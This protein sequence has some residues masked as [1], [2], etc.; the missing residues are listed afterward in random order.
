LRLASY[1]LSV[2]RGERRGAAAAVVRA[3]L[4]AA[5]AFYALALAVRAAA[6]ALGLCRRV[7]VERAVIS[8]GNIVAGGTG[9][10]PMV[11]HLARRLAAHGS[12]PA[13]VARG[14]KA[15][16]AGAAND[17]AMVL[18]ENLPD[19]PQVLDPDRV[20]GAR[21][22]I[23][24]HGAG[25][26]ILDDGFQHWRIERD[27]DLVLVDALEPFGHGHL[28]PRGLLRERP[29]ALG[30]ADAVAITRADLCS[31]DRLAALR[32]EIGRLAPGKPL[33]E[34]VDEAIEPAVLAGKRI[35]AFCGIGNP[36]GFFRR[37]E[38]LGATLVLR[39]AFQDHHAYTP[40]DLAEVREAARRAG[41][42]AIVTTQKDA[43]KLRGFAG[44]EAVL[45]LRIRAAIRS[46]EAELE[47]LVAE[48]AAA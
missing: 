29:G 44:E 21:T 27:L 34:V 13:I 3:V 40:A 43:V 6:Y 1:Y 4:A 2:V 20:R 10:T 30:R 23:E 19:V 11:E 41:A 9:K 28:L 36:E 22:A 32:A 42:E 7:R 14:Y 45:V 17:E 38:R 47:R 24:R 12:R 39:L 25:C 26:V 48:A 33:V 15:A 31:P 35:A 18:R 8:V 5:S 16:S 46:G 37:L